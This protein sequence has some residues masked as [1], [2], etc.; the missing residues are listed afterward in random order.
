MSTIILQAINISG[1]GSCV[2][3]R[4]VLSLYKN[5]SKKNHVIVFVNEN[6]NPKGL[7]KSFFV[8]I[9][10]N[11]FFEKFY[12]YVKILLI[13]D[14]NTKI[15]SFGDFP[16]PF[17]KNQ[18]VFVNQAHLISPGINQYS[19]RSF[20]FVAKRFYFKI[21][22]K[23][24]NTI[25]VQSKH[26]KRSLIKSYNISKKIISVKKPEVD[27]PRFNFKNRKNCKPL[28]FLYPSSHYAHKNHK[29]IY[30]LCKKFFLPNVLIYFT[31]STNEFKIYR[32]L[33][34]IRR[35][36]YYRHKNVYKVF[37]K[38]DAI[39]YPSLIESYGLPLREAFLFKIPVIVS[40]LPYAKEIMKKKA[41]Y[42]NP[43]SQESLHN[44]I[45][46]FKKNFSKKLNTAPK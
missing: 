45:L 18:T 26:M 28:K 5:C 6:A 27:K 41:I 9:V 35:L 31:L 20:I 43:H 17:L 1:L 37:S 3:T 38:F 32:N 22:I 12:F 42:F 14:T 44:S 21:F 2:W 11:N 8:Q 29:L 16:L 39:I 25:I 10:K 40:H 33:K 7:K 4:N 46:H 19:S 23:N 24:I 36:N 30:N 15:I 34:N 13:A